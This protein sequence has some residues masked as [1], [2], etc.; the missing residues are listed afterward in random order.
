MKCLQ[1]AEQQVGQASGLGPAAEA[2]TVVVT[3]RSGGTR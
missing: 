3:A 2:C 1:S